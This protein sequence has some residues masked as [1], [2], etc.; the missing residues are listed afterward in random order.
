MKKIEC[1]NIAKELKQEITDF[2]RGNNTPVLGVIVVG[3]EPASKI[4]VNKKIKEAEEMMFHTRLFKFTDCIPYE[5]LKNN[6]E[7]IVGHCDGVMLQLPLPDHLKPYEDELLSIIPANKDIDGLNKENLYNLTLGLDKETVLPATVKGILTI[8]ERVGE[9]DLTGKDVVVIGR[10][11]TVGKP[12]ISALSNRNATVTWCHSKTK[13][14]IDKTRNADIIISAV[15]IPHFLK[16]VGNENTILIDVG[17]SRDK[18]NKIKGDFHPDCYD[19]CKMY[20]TTPG[21]T[22]VMTVVSLLENLHILYQRSLNEATN[23]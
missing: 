19:K 18:N 3:E 8:L 16:D 17:I 2:Y 10:G 6:I 7:E 20:T 12:I 21:G 13:N 23:R 22:G 14:L 15:G 4:Y 5:T 9:G 1:V 11:K